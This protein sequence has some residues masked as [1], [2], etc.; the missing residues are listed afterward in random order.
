MSL[1]DRLALSSAK[2]FIKDSNSGETACERFL[3]SNYYS[4]DSFIVENSD[5][6]TE[7][8]SENQSD[9]NEV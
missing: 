8:E 3:E 6:V 4:D 5:D 7:G 2:G 1:D 9:S